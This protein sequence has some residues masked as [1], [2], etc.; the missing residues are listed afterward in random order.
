MRAKRIAD[1]GGE[2]SLEEMLTDPVI[3]AVMACDGVAR[4]EIDD[5]VALIQ[6]RCDEACCH[7]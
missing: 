4:D 6:A 2:P 7:C 3:Q 1:F 5:L